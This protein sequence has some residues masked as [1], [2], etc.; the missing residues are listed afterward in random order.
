MDKWVY[1]S[2]EEAEYTASLAFT[3]AVAFVPAFLLNFPVGLFANVYAERKRKKALAASKVKIEATDVL[4]SE[5]VRKHHM[6]ESLL[7]IRSLYL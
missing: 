2:N 4:L 6:N 1:P 5:K 3:I 7:S